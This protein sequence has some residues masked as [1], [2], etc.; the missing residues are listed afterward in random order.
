MLGYVTVFIIICYVLWSLWPLLVIVGAMF[1]SYSGRSIG[2]VIETFTDT[3]KTDGSVVLTNES[4]NDIGPLIP[5][6]TND[7]IYK[8]ILDYIGRFII[9]IGFMYI[10]YHLLIIK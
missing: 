6:S 10:A 3:H 8:P 1:I 9:C 5:D 2:E 4:H 7:L